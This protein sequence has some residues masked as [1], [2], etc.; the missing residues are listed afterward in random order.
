[1]RITEL[2]SDNR[3]LEQTIKDLCASPFIREAGD[4]TLTT[5][6]LRTQ[7]KELEH[8]VLSL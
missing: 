3:K 6:K 4:R 5:A 2:T 8:S 1:M 7:E